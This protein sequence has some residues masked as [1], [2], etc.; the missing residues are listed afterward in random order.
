M[1]QSRTWENLVGR[2][3]GFWHWFYPEL[4]SIFPGALGSV[5]EQSFLRSVSAI[6]PGPIRGDADEV[7][8]GLHIIL[9]FELEQDLLAERFPLE[10]LPEE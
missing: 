7:T 9:R 10:Q 6:R 4:Q 5:D 3:A 8:Y 1:S 2:S